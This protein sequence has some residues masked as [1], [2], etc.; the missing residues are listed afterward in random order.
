MKIC[1]PNVLTRCRFDKLFLYLLECK[2]QQKMCHG[3]YCLLGSCLEYARQRCDFHF[4]V[5][6]EIESYILTK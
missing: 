5:T 1:I 6:H 4:S 2:I 3:L